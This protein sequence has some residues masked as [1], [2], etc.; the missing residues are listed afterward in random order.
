MRKGHTPSRRGKEGTDPS[1][2]SHSSPSLVQA[3]ALHIAT[4]C[5]PVINDMSILFICFI[6]LDCTY[7]RT[8]VNRANQ[9]D[10]EIFLVGA[11]NIMLPFITGRLGGME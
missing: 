8:V 4:L 9:Q 6:P 2:H 7:D 11:N 10:L 5:T 1:S 3:S